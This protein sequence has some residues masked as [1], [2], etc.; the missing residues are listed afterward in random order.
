MESLLRFLTDILVNHGIWALLAF[1]IL[2]II[3]V[4]LIVLVLFMWSSSGK[5]LDKRIAQTLQK[6]K[7]TH[8]LGIQKRKKFSEKVN[9]ILYDIAEKTHADKVL[10]FEY[11]NG[12]SNLI[13]LPFLFASVAAEVTKPGVPTVISQYQKIN[14]ALIANFLVDLEE[15]GSMY[16]ETLDDIKDR[17]PSIYMMMKPNNTRSALFYM[18]QGVDDTLGFI[19]VSTIGDNKLSKKEVLPEVAKVSQLISSIWN[20]DELSELKK[21]DNKWNIFNLW[22]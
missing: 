17:Y 16:V 1:V 15:Q 20:F 19:G 13:G 6:E 2:A 8:R 22:K 12:T 10:L 5:A 14:T 3:F 18:I 9:E 11:T 4:S 7:E 21:E